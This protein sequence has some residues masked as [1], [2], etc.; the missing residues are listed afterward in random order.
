MLKCRECAH[1][2]AVHSQGLDGTH[3]FIFSIFVEM[4]PA[5]ANPCYSYVL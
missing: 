1:L 4:Q 2:I 3:L 5:K